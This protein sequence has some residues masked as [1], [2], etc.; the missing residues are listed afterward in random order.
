VAVGE[1]AAPVGVPCEH[2]GIDV[3][4]E[5]VAVS[6]AALALRACEGEVGDRDQRFGS[7]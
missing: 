5:L 2:L 3:D 6:T 7:L 4:D 1:L